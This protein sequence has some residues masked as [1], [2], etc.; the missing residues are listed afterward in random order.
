MKYLKVLLLLFVVSCSETSIT[1]TK[2]I[3]VKAEIFKI[4]DNSPSCTKYFWKDRGRA[5]LAYIKGMALM[6]ARQVC[7][8]GTEFIKQ[9][10]VVGTYDYYGKKYA[11]RDGLTYYGIEGNELNTYTFLIGLGMR[12]SSGKYCEGRDKS[13]SY[14]KHY[15][16]EAGLFQIA[17]VAK[18]FNTEMMP[19]YEKYKAGKKSCELETFKEGVKCSSYDAINHGEGAGVAWQDLTKKCPAFA[20]EWGAL[21]VR[22]M[23]THFGPIKSKQVEFKN[24]CRD[25]LKS[26]EQITKNNCEAL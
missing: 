11:Q 26:V 4:V 24:E 23:Y 21:M 9:K 7:G 13:M 8:K 15:E 12:E 1:P 3:D 14:V 25:M 16:A 19:I 17:Y 10:K 20:T 6:Y 2:K 5:P 18:T 22:S